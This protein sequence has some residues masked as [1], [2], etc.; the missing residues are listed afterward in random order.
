MKSKAIYYL[1]LGGMLP[2]IF[3]ALTMESVS[4][5]CR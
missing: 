1:L 3:T 5:G 2:F 4:K